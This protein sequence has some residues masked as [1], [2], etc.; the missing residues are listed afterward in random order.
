[1]KFSKQQ[2]IEAPIDY[3]F[4]RATDFRAFERQALRRG[5][6]IAR[7]DDLGQDAVG[8]RWKAA[9]AYRGKR[10]DVDAELI[11]LD[12]PNQFLIQSDSGGIS[13]EFGVEFMPMSAN[14]TRLKIGLQMVPKTLPARLMVQSLK[15]A[16]SSLDLRFARR[17]EQFGTELQDRYQGAS[18]Q[19]L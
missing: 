9:F 5:I 6:E 13:S 17:V 7:I 18:G 4:E 16:K 14:R 15:F 12:A 2:D 3:V 1:M 11:Q 10:R 8:L 19:G